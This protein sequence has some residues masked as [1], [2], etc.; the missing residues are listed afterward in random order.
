MVHAIGPVGGIEDPE[1]KRIIQELMKLGIRPSGNKQI[2]K[3]RLTQIKA[4]QA[5]KILEDKIERSNDNNVDKEREK[6]EEL[7]TGAMQLA[8]INKLLLGL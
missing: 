2:D 4:E 6:L 8:E 5:K 1:Y 3:A 7:K